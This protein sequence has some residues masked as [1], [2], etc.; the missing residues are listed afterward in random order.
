[1]KQRIAQEYPFNESPAPLQF[2]NCV[3]GHIENP[4]Y[5]IQPYSL[6]SRVEHI[7]DETDGLSY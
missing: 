2:A 4:A 5:S 6:G 1:M 7:N 3:P